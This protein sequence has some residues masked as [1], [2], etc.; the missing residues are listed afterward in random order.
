MA[1]PGSPAARRGRFGRD[2]Q[3]RFAD[4][5]SEI[6]ARGWRDVLARTKVDVKRDDVSLLAAGVAFYGLLALV[7]G[8]VALVS[9]YGLVADPDDIRRNV[10]DVLAAA[11]VEVRDL[12]QSQLSSIVRTAPSSLRLG[13]LAGVVL[14]LWAASSGVKNLMTAV[15]RAYHEDETRGFLRIR[16][17]ALAL[18]LGLLVLGAATTLA[19][20]ALDTLSDAGTAGVIKAGLLVVRWGLAGAVLIAGLALIYRVGPDRDD[21][22]W[23]WATPGAALAALI[24]LVA[25]VGFSLYTANFGSYNETYGA[26]GAVIVVMLW[27]YLMAYAVIT[28]AEVNG[29]LERQT[30][31]DT[32]VGHERP[33]GQRDAYA[34]DTVGPSKDKPRP[35]PGSP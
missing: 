35:T 12:V 29:E 14:A 24:G 23:R 5:P 11:P 19:L 13:A 1:T 30:F 17:T 22:R 3:G 9:L 4:R 25:S 33:L 10:D 34:A 2:R 16:A 28:G 27:L 7:P 32:T 20:L 6:P 21:P 26:L 31:A 15:N 18:T 8:L